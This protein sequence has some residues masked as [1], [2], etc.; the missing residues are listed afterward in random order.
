MNAKKLKTS[1]KPRA[2]ATY[3]FPI[4]C[5]ESIFFSISGAMVVKAVFYANDICLSSIKLNWPDHSGE[6]TPIDDTPVDFFGG[7]PFRGSLAKGWKVNVILH[8]LDDRVPNLTM[9]P[10]EERLSW[11]DFDVEVYD[12][13]VTVG[14]KSGKKTLKL[15]YTPRFG[16]FMRT[17]KINQ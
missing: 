13:M 3:N 9:K 15:V 16:G 7:V 10:T 1:E 2:N 14:S 6:K 5:D 12:E 11:D 4:T 17:D 8:V